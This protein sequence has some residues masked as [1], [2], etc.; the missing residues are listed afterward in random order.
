MGKR[1]AEKVSRMLGDSSSH[2][3]IMMTNMMMNDIDSTLV[4]NQL[5]NNQLMNNQMMKNQ[6]ISQIMK[7]QLIK[8]K[9][10]KDQIIKNKLQSSL[11]TNPLLDQLT[12]NSMLNKISSI[13]GKREADKVS[14]MLGGSSSLS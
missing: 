14:N 12:L 1:D 13:R 9:I 5:M 3:D 10:M 4:N 8:N 11:N 6:M 7:N 2:S